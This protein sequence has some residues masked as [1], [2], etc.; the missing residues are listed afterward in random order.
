MVF[1]GRGVHRGQAIVKCSGG[2]KLRRDGPLAFFI[3]KSPL[4]VHSRRS[5]AAVKKTFSVVKLRRN[6]KPAA[7]INI[8]YLLVLHHGKTSRESEILLPNSISPRR[9]N[10]CQ[11]N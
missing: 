5:R 10:V 3:D 2:N 7:A 9:M 8:A 11:A 1:F 6:N 4:T